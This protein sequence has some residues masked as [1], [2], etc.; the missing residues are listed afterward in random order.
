MGYLNA[1]ELSRVK[2]IPDIKTS[3]QELVTDVSGLKTESVTIID[4]QNETNARVLSDSLLS[5][6]IDLKLE[7]S[8][9]LTNIGLP[10]YD[11]Q[12]FK[13]T[14]TAKNG[15]KTTIDLPIES[16]AANLDYD[17]STKSIIVYKE[18]GSTINV[19]VVDLVD[20]YNGSTG[21]HVQISIGSN[22]TINA[23]LLSGSIDEDKITS[24]LLSKINLSHS[25]SNKS[26][27]DS[28]TEAFTTALKNAYDSTVTWITS[29]GTNLLN[30]LSNTVSHVTQSDKDG[31]NS[32]KTFCVKIVKSG[33]NVSIAKG[34]TSNILQYVNLSTDAAFNNVT[35][36]DFSM[37]N[38]GTSTALIKMLNVNKYVDYSFYI[39]LIGSIAGAGSREFFIDLQRSD[40]SV[41]DGK[42]ILK[43]TSTALDKRG[44]IIESFSTG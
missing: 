37:S 23:E 34:A 18:D 29:N 22:N 36:S 2:E 14:F 31:W 20:V 40:N 43:L 16:L 15:S 30:H 1:N 25:H 32:K 12:L 28:I 17:S 19:P 33:L 24:N 5:E 44:E 41:V 4:L 9:D 6:R 13:I 8:A 35:L 10:E 7:A 11:D 27:L 26:V 42:S 21:T 38:Q 3:V 39:R